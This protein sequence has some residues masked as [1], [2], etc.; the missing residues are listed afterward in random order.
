ML[1]HEKA[2]IAKRLQKKSLIVKG[3]PTKNFSLPPPRREAGATKTAKIIVDRGK[4]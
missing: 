2:G 3:G 4:K 1:T